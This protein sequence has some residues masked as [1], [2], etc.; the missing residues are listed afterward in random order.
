MIP[1]AAAGPASRSEGPRILVVSEYFPDDLQRSVYGTFQRLRILLEAARTVGG[2]DL[3]FFWAGHAVVAEEVERRY[4]DIAAAWKIDGAM[5]VCGTKRLAGGPVILRR[6]ADLPW[7]MRGIVGFYGGRPTIHS[8]GKAQGQVTRLALAELRPNLVVAHRQGA[9]AALRRAGVPLPP[10]VIDVD[11]LDH[12]GLQ[13]AALQAPDLAVRLS[14]SAWSIMARLAERRSVR[15][16]RTAL[17]CSEVDR[18]KLLAL[19]PGA[20]VRVL[21]NAVD[22]LP[23]A[24][25][26]DD[27]V[28]VFIG[29]FRYPPNAEAAL[30]FMQGSWP[31]IRAAIPA[32]R[33]LFVGEDGDSLLDS[34]PPRMGIEVRGFVDSL[35]EI[36]ANARLVVCPIRR[37]SGTRIKIIE[38]AAYG[39]PVVATTVGA[40]GLE[41]SNGREIL[42]R[43]QPDD[44]AQACVSLLRDKAA[45]EKLGRA[46]RDVVSAKYSRAGAVALASRIIS[47][48]MLTTA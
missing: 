23:L 33:L 37:G 2:V 32:A 39:R 21:P 5:W 46:A 12:V 20:D 25:L 7:V 6:L 3:L 19:A 10:V 9:M 38:A 14:A 29:V 34:I 45:S 30:W 43:D 18:E 26:P 8:C 40:E 15:L 48:A 4:A 28:V 17:V 1:Y 11:D 36:Y 22:V 16:S 27:P 24:P 35:Q 13:R 42:I 47:E 41:F 31:L 44:F